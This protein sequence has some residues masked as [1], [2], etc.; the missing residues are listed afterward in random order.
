MSET[1]TPSAPDAEELAQR[2]REHLR[3]LL[4]LTREL[5]R[6]YRRKAS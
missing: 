1:D 6:P 2:I 5:R 4:A 3:K